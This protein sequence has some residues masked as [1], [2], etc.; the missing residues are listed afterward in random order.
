MPIKKSNSK[1]MHTRLF[2]NKSK[3]KLVSKKAVPR[4]E[5]FLERDAAFLNSNPS[6]RFGS[7]LDTGLYGEVVLLENNE[8]MVAKAPK[9]FIHPWGETE[10]YRKREVK[11]SKAGI[12]E[13]LDAYKKYSLGQRPLFIPTHAVMMESDFDNE[14]YPVLLRPVVSPIIDGKNYKYSTRRLVT[15]AILEDIRRKVIS[16]SHE[17]IAFFDGLQLGLDETGRPLIFDAGR[18]RTTRISEAFETNNKMWRKFLT[19]LERPDLDVRG[20]INPRERY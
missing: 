1:D 17:G 14:R 15:D 19:K 2:G 13:E 5:A 20:E 8:N 18:V 12:Q 3:P 10:S 11:K 16:L 4:K 6:I 7:R 9:Y